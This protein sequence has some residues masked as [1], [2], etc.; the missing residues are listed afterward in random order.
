MVFVYHCSKNCRSCMSDHCPFNTSV[1][2]MFSLKITPLSV[3]FVGIKGEWVLRSV[4]RLYSFMLVLCAVE[5]NY[6]CTYHLMHYCQ[7]WYCWLDDRKEIQ[8]I[9]S[10]ASTI[11]RSS[12]SGNCACGLAWNTSSKIGRLYTKLMSASWS[13]H[14]FIVSC[15]CCWKIFNVKCEL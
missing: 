15:I 5:G 11:H 9:G 13:F 6:S 3:C 8:S 4:T 12:I 10:P 1:I 2:K 14:L 7:C